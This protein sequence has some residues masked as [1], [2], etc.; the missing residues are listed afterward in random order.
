MNTTTMAA[1]APARTNEITLMSATVTM[2][3]K[4][5]RVPNPDSATC[6]SGPNTWFNNC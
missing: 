4:P 6:T 3:S 2:P 5:E 1:S